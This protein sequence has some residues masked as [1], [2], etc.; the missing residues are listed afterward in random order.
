MTTKKRILK[1]LDELPDDA[2]IEEYMERL[3]LLYKVEQGIAD[4]DAGRKFTQEEARE[5]MKNW[6]S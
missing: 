6:L 2:D 4:A 5:R 1:A 3:Y